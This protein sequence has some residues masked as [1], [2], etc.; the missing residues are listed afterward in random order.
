MLDHSVRRSVLGMLAIAAAA[1]VAAPHAADANCNLIPAVQREFRSTRQLDANQPASFVLATLHF[2]ALGI[3]LSPLAI[4]QAVLANTPGGAIPT[5]LS[6][7]SIEV[8]VPERASRAR[9]RVEARR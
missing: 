6:G 3:G 8:V 4:T 2:T 1:V 7:T 5:T 9:G